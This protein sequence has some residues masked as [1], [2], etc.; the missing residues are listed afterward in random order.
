MPWPTTRSASRAAASKRLRASFRPPTSPSETSPSRSRF[1]RPCGCGARSSTMSRYSLSRRNFLAGIGGAAGL[2]AFL[3]H[4][5]AQVAGPAELRRLLI[6]QRPVGTWPPNWFPTGDG[7]N[8][9]LSPI[10]QPLG[11]HRDSMVVFDSFL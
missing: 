1:R 7:K 4:V 5:E 11:A 8:Y 2:G 6:L 10:L 3:E 9:T